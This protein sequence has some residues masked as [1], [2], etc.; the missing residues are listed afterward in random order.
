MVEIKMGPRTVVDLPFLIRVYDVSERQFDRLAEP[1]T[2]AELIDGVMIVHSLNAMLHDEVSNFVRELM[3][4]YAG[5]RKAGRGYGPMCLFQPGK[6]RRLA[7]DVFYLER[8]RVPRP[9][10]KIFE[11]VPDQVVEVLSPSN[12]TYDL[13]EKR[14][15]YRRHRVRE[16][17]LI[18]PDRQF[19]EV[20][21]LTPDG[22]YESLTVTRGRLESHVL[23]GFWLNVSWLWK[24][25]PPDT[26]RCLRSILA[27]KA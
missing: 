8:A 23:A 15:L 7:P 10:P 6:R 11:G 5:R 22:N 1:G 20:D 12:R 9:L 2:R 18:D 26:L 3:N 24:S 25:P 21:R 19:V 16:I 4:L 13:K 27:S 17:W 14:P